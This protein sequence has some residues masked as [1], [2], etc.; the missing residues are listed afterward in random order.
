MSNC[1]QCAVGVLTQT[2]GSWQ[3][4][5]AYISKQ[6]DPVA[7]GWPE[8]LR[9]VAATA[10]VLQEADKLT[11]G[12]DIPVYVPHTVQTLVDQRGEKWLTDAR[13]AKYQSAITEN[14]RVCLQECTTLNPATLLPESCPSKQVYRDCLQ[15]MDKV[16][17]SRP[18]LRDQPL[19]DP[20]TLLMG[21]V[22]S[23]GMGHGS[24]GTQL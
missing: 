7:W 21:A 1:Q 24:W 12:Q 23:P 15:V 14:P 8:C 11:L 22:T 2:V 9:A 18:N 10:L 4:P 5:V 6:L 17:S 19:K 3:R 20:V 13:M 16:F